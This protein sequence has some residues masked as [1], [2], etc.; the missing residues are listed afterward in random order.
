[1]NIQM[2]NNTKIVPATVS[3]GFEPEVPGPNNNSV[4]ILFNMVPVT[5]AYNHGSHKKN[6]TDT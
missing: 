1:M 6:F 4:L 2:Q 3:A 5:R